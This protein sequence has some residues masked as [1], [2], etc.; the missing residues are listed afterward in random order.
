LSAKKYIRSERTN[1]FEPNVY[2]TMVVELEGTIEP[3]EMETAV[4][5]AYEANE[6]TMSKIVLEE[7]GMAWYEKQD[8]SGCKIHTDKRSWKE[9]LNENEK[10]PFRLDIGEFVRTFILPGER[11]TTL[12]VMAHHLTGDGKGIVIL[13]E[14]MLKSLNKDFLEYK[15]LELLDEN[16]LNQY[17]MPLSARLLINSYNRKWSRTRL[18]FGWEDYRKIHKNYWEKHKSDF[19]IRTV[20][21]EELSNIK[22]KAHSMG[23]TMNSY[24]VAKLHNEYP[25]YDGVG[26]PISLRANSRSVSN[27]TSGIRIVNYRNEQQSFEENAKRV[28][29]MIYKKLASEKTRRFTLAF[30]AALHPGLI[31]ATLLQTHHCFESAVTKRMAAIIGYQGGNNKKLGITN[32]GNIDIKQEYSFFQVTD[33]LFLPPK[34][35]Y[36]ETIIGISTFAGKM[37][38]SVI[39]CE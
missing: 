19:S 30:V 28:H 31:D 23:I 29:S 18:H 37:H 3:K 39:Q 22:Q 33:L 6:V 38:C 10:I 12:L 20:E 14:D 4:Q 24:L 8:R 13:I 26:I 2:I 17:R 16:F 21:G 32:L 25:E 35:S 34:V 15:E 11:T 36:S 9:I 1:L 5:K 27:Q 7:T